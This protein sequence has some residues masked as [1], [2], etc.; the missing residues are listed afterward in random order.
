[1]R[2]SCCISDMFQAGGS[3][4]CVLFQE[5]NVCQLKLLWTRKDGRP[6]SFNYCKSVNEKPT[7]LFI[8]VVILYCDYYS[9]YVNVKHVSAIEKP[10]FLLLLQ[11]LVSW[12]KGWTNTLT[13]S[14]ININCIYSC[15][16]LVRLVLF[17]C[18][19]MYNRVM[20]WLMTAI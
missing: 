16:F 18:S 13:I 19:P 1:M 2:S 15:L 8:F 14:K 17:G 12:P 20:K 9:N 3:R 7:A 11:P 6:V 10:L 5:D 4:V